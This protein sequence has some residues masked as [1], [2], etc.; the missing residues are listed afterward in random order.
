MI[1]G[2]LKPQAAERLAL[3]PVAS[4]FRRKSTMTSG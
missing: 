1:F 2:R 3:V 4:D